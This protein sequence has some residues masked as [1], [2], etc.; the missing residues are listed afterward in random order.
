MQVLGV[1]KHDE[2]VRRTADQHSM[3]DYL[4][5]DLDDQLDADEVVRIRVEHW[6]RVDVV[7]NNIGSYR[8]APAQTC[9]T[10]SVI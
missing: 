2:A 6:G 1:G 8:Q 3:I 4:V 10:R 9:R 7:V 5:A